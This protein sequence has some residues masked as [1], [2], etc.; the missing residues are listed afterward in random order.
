LSFWIL[1]A[2]C[3]LLGQH[4]QHAHTS[5]NTHNEY[6]KLKV[7]GDVPP[8]KA[9][10]PKCKD[11]SERTGTANG[12][13]RHEK[14]RQ[15]RDRARGHEDTRSRTR[16]AESVSLESG[17]ISGVRS[18][19]R[20]GRAVSHTSWCWSHYSHPGRSQHSGTQLLHVTCLTPPPMGM[21]CYLL[22]DP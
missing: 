14:T 9:Q 2:Y 11:E 15:S 21:I 1:L 3:L 7:A 17:V 12:R 8:P 6:G 22:Q 19:T 10:C 13:R 4:S 16:G 18:R 20:R 5:N